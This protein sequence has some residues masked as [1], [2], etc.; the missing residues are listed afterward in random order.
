ME[1]N[2]AIIDKLAG[3]SGLRF[4]ETDKKNLISDL[5]NMIAFVEKLNEV[6]TDDIEPLLHMSE[7]KNMLREDIVTESL[8]LEQALANAPLKDDSFFKVP[9]VINK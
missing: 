7:N 8:S 5:S 3:L 6:N 2:E 4:E 9:K 1:I